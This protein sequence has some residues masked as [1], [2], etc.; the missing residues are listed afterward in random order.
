[1]VAGGRG[2]SLV[3]FLKLRER[4]KDK[5]NVSVSALEILMFSEIA[6]NL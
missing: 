4:C 5:N 3:V 2:D 6:E 1:M